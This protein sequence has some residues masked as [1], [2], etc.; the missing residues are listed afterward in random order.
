MKPENLIC[1]GVVNTRFVKGEWD[2]YEW[3]NKP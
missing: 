3:L 2:L 1:T